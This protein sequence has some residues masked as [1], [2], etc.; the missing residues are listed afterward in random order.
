MVSS[1]DPGATWREENG[2][3]RE[4]RQAQR[5]GPTLRGAGWVLGA[6]LGPGHEHLYGTQQ[7]PSFC[8]CR[9]WDQ[10]RQAGHS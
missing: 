3:S 4:K 1:G 10:G 2:L 9:G 8:P 7:T 6:D 5:V